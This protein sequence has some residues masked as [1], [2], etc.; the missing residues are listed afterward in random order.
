MANFVKILDFQSEFCQ[1]FGLS[2]EFLTFFPNIPRQD[3]LGLL[4][5][6][7]ILVGN[8][9][10]GIIEASYFGTPVVNIGKRQDGREKS[11]NII[12]CLDE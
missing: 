3:Y 2:Y 4:K 7:V 6:K 9:S 1:N 10:S 8:S 12:D 5:N 11:N